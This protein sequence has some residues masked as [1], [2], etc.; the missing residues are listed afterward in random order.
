M[1]HM[2]KRRIT[3]RFLQQDA[4]LHPVLQ[5]QLTI[6]KQI[7]INNLNVLRSSRDK[8]SLSHLPKIPMKF[9]YLSSVR[10]LER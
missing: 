6:P 1:P 7:H 5:P 9:L 3:A 2:T 4:V 8:V 10:R